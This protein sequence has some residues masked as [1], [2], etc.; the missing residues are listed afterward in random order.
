MTKKIFRAVFAASITVLTASIILIMGVLYDY[1]NSVRKSELKS[2]LALAK[3]AVETEGISYLEKLDIKN[4][5][6]T[7]IDSDGK[8][9]FDNQRN[10]ENMENHIQREE[11][12]EAF[13]NGIGESER[14]S[15]TLTEKTMYCAA[16]LNNNTV[17]RVSVSQLT[18]PT[19]LLGILQPIAIVFVIAMIISF[20]LASRISKRIVNPLNSLDLDNPLEND[21]YDEIAPLLKRIDSQQEKIRQQTAELE[22]HKNEFSAITSNMN[23]G[24]ILLG[25][26]KKIISLNPAAD[27]FLN[28]QN[29]GI[30]KPF[31][32]I[33]RN[34]DII[35]A[36]EKAESD[37]I[38]EIKINRNGR[39]YQLNI[40]CIKNTGIPSGF[41]ILIFD[42]TEKNNAE[43]HRR[44]FTAN[45]SHE[46]KTPIQSIMGSAELIENGLVKK[47]DIPKFM[48][49]I[50]S[51]SSRLVS[52][53]NDIIRLSQLDEG[54]NLPVQDFDLYQLAEENI[55]IL[56]DAASKK[57]IS[58]LISGEHIN[59]KSV[60]PLASEMIYNLLD[61]AIKYNNNNGNVNIKISKDEKGI[62]LIVS[63]NGIGIPPEHQER[64]FE[65]FYRVDKSRSKET[66]GTGLGLSIVKHAAEDIGATIQ[67]ES[68][69]GQGTEITIRF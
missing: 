53:I 69:L 46:L 62:F 61:N 55:N 25:T 1:F 66:G 10:S 65:R 64:I 4:Y 47:E 57:N 50:R 12:K 51:E 39:I 26:D 7:L 56:K 63:D 14:Y 45:V 9:L 58:I 59:I 23:E 38:C 49:N 18:V 28:I 48:A 19:L 41:V 22:K 3:I 42:I 27:S 8:V 40:S 32:E 34:L 15:S 54:T 60:R 11:V 43:K 37:D 29:S 30:G 68:V 33:E 2:E 21:S 6:L 35:N 5:R 52:L 13:K 17:L 24:L 67:L 16:L 20:I 31:I 44:E 36:I